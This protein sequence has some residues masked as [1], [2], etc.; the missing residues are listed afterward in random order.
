MQ[1]TFDL[2]GV[3]AHNIQIMDRAFPINELAVS[4]LSQW[5]NLKP[6]LTSDNILKKDHR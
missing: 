2:T 6:V 4:T 1:P 3:R 5:G